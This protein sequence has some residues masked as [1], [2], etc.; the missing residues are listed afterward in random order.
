VNVHPINE[1]QSRLGSDRGF[2]KANPKHLLPPTLLLS[3][4]AVWCPEKKNLKHQ[5]RR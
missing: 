2:E 4:A 1:L 3:A 5:K